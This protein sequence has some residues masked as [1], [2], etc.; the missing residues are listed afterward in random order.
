MMFLNHEVDLLLSSWI[1]AA[2]AVLDTTVELATA[3]K[4]QS[5]NKASKGSTYSKYDV[6]V[7]YLFYKLVCITVF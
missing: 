5:N 1:G 4:A 6:D 2:T 3:S 7:F